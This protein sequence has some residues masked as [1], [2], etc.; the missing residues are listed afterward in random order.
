VI[1]QC[2]VNHGTLV[3]AELGTRATTVAALM[4]KERVEYV[5][6]TPSYWRQFLLQVP[7]VDVA[8]FP[9]KQITLGGEAV[10]QTILDRIM[11]LFPAARV[12]HI[13]ATTE[14]GRCFS[15]SDGRAGFP[16]SLLEGVSRDAVG[17]K[18]DD[19]ELL[20][21]SENAMQSYDR[22]SG[23]E[24][25]PPSDWFRTG[26]LVERREDRVY[27][28]GRKSDIINVGGNKVNPTEVEQII[29]E[30]PGIIDLLVY[31]KSSS[32]TGE[33]VA[34]DLVLAPGVE[35]SAVKKALGLHCASRLT[36]YQRPRF[37]RVVDAIQLSRS[38]K[39]KR[40]EA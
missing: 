39:K 33:L 16:A 3:L 19:G 5:S 27:F 29:R 14:L 10:D 13:Y 4:K 24:A 34:C 26:D 25:S 40:T 38:G 36:P 6:A 1:L 21:R 22:L 35:A 15:V 12:V 18:I 32:V 31:R 20:A 30:L 2:L 17:L 28:V 37:V 8:D 7:P 9:L 23:T 11:Q